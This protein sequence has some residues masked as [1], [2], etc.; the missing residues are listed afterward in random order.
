MKRNNKMNKKLF[1]F[2]I[3]PKNNNILMKNKIT[4]NNRV[5]IIKIK[6]PNK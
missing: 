1:H 2:K 6:N 5:K 4:F 3:L